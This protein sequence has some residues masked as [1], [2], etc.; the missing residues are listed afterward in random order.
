MYL[1][2]FRKNDGTLIYKFYEFYT[3]YKLGDCNS[4]GWRV[5]SVQVLFKRKFIDEK[6][7]SEILIKQMKIQKNKNL[8][9]KFLKSHFLELVCLLILL[10]ILFILVFK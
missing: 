9:L 2:V 7:Y 10:I 6:D 8:G 5:I 1:V 4:Y 3:F